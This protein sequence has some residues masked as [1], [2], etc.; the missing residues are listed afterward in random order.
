MKKK[1]SFFNELHMTT[2]TEIL[3]DLRMFSHSLEDEDGYSAALI[4]SLKSFVSR[5]SKEIEARNLPDL[6]KWWH[7]RYEITGNGAEL[8]MC[9]CSSIEYDLGGDE[10]K[11]EQEGESFPLIAIPAKYLETQEFIEK[12]NLPAT[13]IEDLIRSGR[14]QHVVFEDGRW[15]ISE[16]QESP[17]LSRGSILFTLPRTKR[18][19]PTFSKFPFP[20]KLLAS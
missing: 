18:R 3:N 5:F 20:A 8:R 12:Y 17:S 10:I 1:L 15:L 4:N 7:Y 9:Y 11:E 6:D 16:L 2:K 14:I 13:D 19:V